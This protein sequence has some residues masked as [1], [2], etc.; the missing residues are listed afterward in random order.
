MSSRK[1]K[2]ESLLVDL[3]SLKRAM[4]FRMDA[5]A[6]IPRITPSQCGVLMFMEERSESTVK[7]VAQALGITSS[8]AT[9]LVDGLVSSGY[10]AKETHPEDRRA[11]TLT[12]PK[13]TKTQ[14]KKMKERGIQKFLEIFQVLSDEEFDQYLALN[15]KI[16]RGFLA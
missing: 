3:R 15:K 12:L 1:K 7:D 5:A 13:K 11:V 14:V 4:T 16:V 8:A 2:V 6:D 10:V 9:Q